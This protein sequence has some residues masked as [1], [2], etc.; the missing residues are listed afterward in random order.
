MG[1]VISVYIRKGGSGKTTTAINLASGLAKEGKKVLLVD[2]DSQYNATISLG[3]YEPEKDIKTVLDGNSTV[4]DSIVEVAGFYLL[5]GSGELQ[6][7]EAN[8][9]NDGFILARIQNMLEPIK[10]EYDYIIIDTPPASHMLVYS[11]L[12]ASDAVIIPA[13]VH[14][15]SVKGTRQALSM[16]DDVEKFT[17]RE[18]DL[19]GI[20]PT[21]LQTHTNVGELLLEQLKKLYGSKVLPFS[22]P[23]TVRVIESQSVGQPLLDY[24]PENSASEAYRKLA[25]FVIKRYN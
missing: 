15:L 2:M 10:N 4:Q 13:Q 16:I 14:V 22:I 3:V 12:N 17:K 6:N 1:K 11:A 8:A 20:L 19:I 25:K 7:N 5:P 18:V 21:M 24:A 23:M 9:I